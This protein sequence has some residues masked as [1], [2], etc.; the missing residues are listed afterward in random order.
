[1]ITEQESQ[2]LIWFHKTHKHL[3]NLGGNGDYLGIERNVI[4]TQWVRDIFNRLDFQV[5]GVLKEEL[6]KTY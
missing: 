3:R 5:V 1:M 2:K 4:Q 6:G